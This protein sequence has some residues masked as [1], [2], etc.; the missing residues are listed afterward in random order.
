[1]PPITSL[2]MSARP[3]ALT[4]NSS[5]FCCSSTMVLLIVV[6]LS[7]VVDQVRGGVGVRASASGTA[8]SMSWARFGR[9]GSI[10]AS[11]ALKSVSVWPN[12][13]PRPLNAVR[14]RAERLVQLGGIDL[15]EHA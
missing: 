13:S 4:R 5:R 11:S 2:P 8:A 9:L 1:M 14:D 7:N 3:I 10:L 15:V 6:V 12:F